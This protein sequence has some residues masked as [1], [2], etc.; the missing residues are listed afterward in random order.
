MCISKHI[1]IGFFFKQAAGIDKLDAHIG[2]VFRQHQNIHSNIDSIV[3]DIDSMRK[4]N[5]VWKLLDGVEIERKMLWE[6]TAWDKRFK[7]V[8][9]FKQPNVIKYHYS[10][11]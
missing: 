11:D 8:D 10:T 4:V 9:K 7:G 3:A 2:F 1:V 5:C 6:V